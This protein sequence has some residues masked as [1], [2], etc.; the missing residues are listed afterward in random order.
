MIERCG[1]RQRKCDGL[2][3]WPLHFF[4]EG[5]PVMLQIALLL[6]ACGL[7]RY[8]WTVNAFVAYTLISLT[9]LGVVF[10]IGIVI[11]GMTSYACP[12]QT[13]ASNALRGLRK[14]VW[15]GIVSPTVHSKWAFSRAFLVWNQNIR[16][17]FHPQSPQ[18]IPLENVQVQR[19]ESLSALDDTRQS[20]PWV[21][22]KDLAIIRRTNT[23]D[24]RCVSWV[25]RN[26]TD[27]EAL[28]AAIRLAGEI[29]WFDD[30][31]DVDL[32]YDL[33]VSTYEACFDSIGKLYSGS[34]DRAYYSGRAVL[35]IRTL[36]VYK[37]QEFAIRFPLPVTNCTTPNL[38]LDLIN[39]LRV[40]FEVGF[41][42]WR[43]VE[44]L[45]IN[46]ECTPSH[47]QWISDILLHYC[48]A[49]RDNLNHG[50]FLDHI[51]NA[52]ET[53]TPIPLNAT[54]NRL[55]TWCIFLGLPA[56]GEALEIQDKSYDT[57]VFT[58]QVTH[59][60]LYQ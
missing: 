43:A 59:S 46:L 10:Y 7:C 48:W 19:S 56:E 13:P 23:D 44:L 55:L 60:A 9:G 18:T 26:I 14:K 6:L 54:L 11:A 40:G 28:D 17:F 2:E 41:P 50:F 52:I 38:D 35:W 16:P 42:E 57:P 3:K 34:R 37:S 24:A 27:P 21:Q 45:T 36:A 47:S 22:P 51:P 20:E 25:L 30:G 53:K 58:L 12:F 31:T 39:L 49:N 32:P 33:I 4:V 5:L 15:D 8:M 1:D 29:R